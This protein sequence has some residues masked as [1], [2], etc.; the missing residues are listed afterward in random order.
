MNSQQQLESEIDSAWE[1][2]R[3]IAEAEEEDDYSDD[4]VS[5]DRTEA[6]G[7]A[8]GLARAYQVIYKEDYPKVEA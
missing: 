3:Q 2:Y 5:M 6:E 7:Y 4:M 8:N 1:E